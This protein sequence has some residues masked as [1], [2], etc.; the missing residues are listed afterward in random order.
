ME[1][2]RP[3]IIGVGSIGSI[4]TEKISNDNFFEK[5]TIIDYDIVKERNLKNSV[6]TKN[7]I[8]KKKVISLYE[9]FSNKI[10]MDI[11]D[12]KFDESKCNEIYDTDLIIDCRDF[13][14]NRNNIDIRLFVYSKSL[15]ID[16]RRSVNYSVT[17]EGTYFWNVTKSELELLLENFVAKIKNG[18]VRKLLLEQDVAEVNQNYNFETKNDSVVCKSN[19]LM[20]T[21]RK[22]SNPEVVTKIDHTK[23]RNINVKFCN[24]NE[25]IKSKTLELYNSDFTNI[26]NEINNLIPKLDNNSYLLVLENN[27]ILIIPETGAA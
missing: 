14:Y 11:L 20:D 3:L 13:L 27:E 22:I 10:K 18:S 9:K 4:L 12:Q 6:F 21:N 16:C 8:G 24:T 26:I 17:Y 7:D 15:I 19:I 5:I 25:R 1:F 2:K 23:T